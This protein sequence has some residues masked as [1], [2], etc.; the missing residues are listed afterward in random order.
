MIIRRH[1]T[2]EAQI[3]FIANDKFLRSLAL[4]NINMAE[5]I[6]SNNNPLMRQN[7]NCLEIGGAG[8]ITKILRPNWKV[9]DIRAAPG[10]DLVASAETLPFPDSSFDIILAI[11]VIH[12]IRDKK[13]FFKEISR[14][15]KKGDL[16]EH[17]GVVGE[18]GGGIFFVREPYWSF[19][20]QFIWRFLHPESFSLREL[21]STDKY[22]DPMSGN[23]AFA[24]ALIKKKKYLEKNLIPTD[25]K[26]SI[27]GPV[28]GL[29]FLLSGGNTFST[30]FN[31]SIIQKIHKWETRHPVWLKFFGF[32][33]YFYFSKK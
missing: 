25:L 24:Y 9:T 16:D 32:S 33:V 26:L 13:L 4:E 10:V 23:Q 19:P 5:T 7:I 14:L 17:H 12:H 8:G 22:L 31:R 28:N 21:N 20:A 2:F 30:G 6:H 15:L 27:L 29:G 1:K 18:R 11:D 3:N